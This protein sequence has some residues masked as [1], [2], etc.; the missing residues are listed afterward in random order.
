MDNATQPNQPSHP[1]LNRIK[2]YLAGIKTGSDPSAPI[3]NLQNL[4]TPKPP[5][6]SPELTTWETVNNISLPEAYRL[7]LLEIGNGGMMPGSY[8]D[9]VM[10]PLGS[11][12]VDPKIQEA[13]PITKVRLQQRMAQL[14][15]EGRGNDALFPELSQYWEEGM[16]PGC[17]WLGHYPSYDFVYL[18]VSGELSGMV[19]CAVDDGVPE[20]N[21]QGNPF[22]FLE[23]FEDTLLDLSKSE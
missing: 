8:C 4:Y 19:W 6:T 7:F 2:A 13:F 5:L 12:R 21:S 18:I 16:P 23:W 17:L 20:L 3:E 15:I 11:K 10:H 14:K 9:F 1:T 22:D